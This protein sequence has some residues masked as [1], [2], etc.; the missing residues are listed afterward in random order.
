MY[1]LICAFVLS[2]AIAVGADVSGTWQ[3]SVETSQGSGSPMLE[4]RQN[5]EQ[6]TGTFHSQIFGDAKLTGSVKGNTIEFGFEG[7]AG[8]QTIKVAYKGTIESATSMKGTAVYAG[9]DDRATW[10]ATKK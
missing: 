3:L 7:N 8:D 2:A 4:L 1:K 10:T 6:L 9:F 5:G